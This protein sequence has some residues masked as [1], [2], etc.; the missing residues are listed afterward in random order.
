MRYKLPLTGAQ[1]TRM[2]QYRL[3]RSMLGAHKHPTTNEEFYEEAALWKEA[4][5]EDYR[6]NVADSMM[7]VHKDTCF[8]YVIQQG[9]RK[10]K[11]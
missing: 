7:H 2:P 4:Y 5:C 6:L 10:A 11:H 9:L 8:K 3:L 1:I